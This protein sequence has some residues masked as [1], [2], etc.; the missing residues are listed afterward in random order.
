MRYAA[1]LFEDAEQYVPIVSK[2]RD[3]LIGFLQG[4]HEYHDTMMALLEDFGMEEVLVSPYDIDMFNTSSRKYND[5]MSDGRRESLL[6]KIEKT[7][8]LEEIFDEAESVLESE[9]IDDVEYS[10]VLKIACHCGMGFYSWKT[11][12]DI[13]HDNVKCD[14]CGRHLIHYNG[15][16]DWQIDYENGKGMANGTC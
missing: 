14:I 13:P 1:P 6:T 4:I 7:S 15:L 5:L 2:N 10:D 11:L 16:D 9:D 3:T 8:M 12:R